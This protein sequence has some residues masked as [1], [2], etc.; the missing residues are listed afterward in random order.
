MDSARKTKWIE[1]MLQEDKVK[2]EGL[3]TY[4]A[5]NKSDTYTDVGNKE[6]IKFP[7]KTKVLDTSQTVALSRLLCLNNSQLQSLSFL[8]ETD[9]NG[10]ALP[11][12]ES[13]C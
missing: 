4:L 10:G 9:W 1:G 8:Y 13:A 5:K 11:L 7:T 3:L 6:R 12:K 2:T